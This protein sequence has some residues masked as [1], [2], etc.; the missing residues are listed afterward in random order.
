[1]KKYN[2][3]RIVFALGMSIVTTFGLIG[4]ASGT[5]G[6]TQYIELGQY[7]GL[8]IQKAVHEVTEEEI[9]DEL[10]T[11][12]G[13]YATEEVLTEGAV[14]MG[15]VAN[16]D[17]LGKKDGVA[18]NGGTAN[19]YDLEIGSGS[20]IDGFED[21]LVGVNVGETVDLPLRFPDEYHSKE[22]AGA[23][24]I[25]TVTVNSIKRKNAPEITD[26]FISEISDGK[27][28]DVESYKAALEQQIIDEYEEYNKLQYYEDLWNAAVENAT[29]I[30]DF[31]NELV[32]E[33]TS[34]M[35]LNAQEYARSYGMNFDDFVSQKMGISKDEFYKQ[36]AEYANTAAKESLVLEAIATAENIT[37]SDEELDKAIN[38]YVELGRYESKEDFLSKNNIDDFREYILT[39]K[40]QDFLA[41]NAKQ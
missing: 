1:M 6:A 13:A 29:V 40:V 24:V 12:A 19:G 3:N 35:V 17:Y 9:E 15:D 38:E 18:F 10:N 5:S 2:I 26:E 28:S 25:F 27:Y 39:S 30:N 7:K 16:I 8:D 22:L 21:G 11:L 41:E 20:F 37:V 14:Q 36:A 33:K 34:R 4:C 23:D 32:N 31:P